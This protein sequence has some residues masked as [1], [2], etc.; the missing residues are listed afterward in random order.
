MTT[1]RLISSFRLQT[2]TF[3]LVLTSTVAGQAEVR[4]GAV[5]GSGEIK[6]KI[7]VSEVCD[8]HYY[9]SGERVWIYKNVEP[10]ISVLDAN[11][12]NSV[13]AMFDQEVE[14]DTR[15]F[16]YAVGRRLAM[17][18]VNKPIETSTCTVLGFSGT[19]GAFANGDFAVTPGAGLTNA[20]LTAYA[21]IASDCGLDRIFVI[22]DS[23]Q[24]ITGI[25]DGYYWLE[26][27]MR[28]AN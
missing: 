14:Y 1:N 27:Y 20:I 21:H 23:A 5:R 6:Y 8:A 2:A 22:D 25:R 10:G 11:I 12:R 16:G 18:S 15:A 7:T 4:G 3:P 26:C 17:L 9:A 19:A 28:L 24:L 13:R